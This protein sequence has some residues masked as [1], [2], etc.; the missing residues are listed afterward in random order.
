MPPE[1]ISPIKQKYSKIIWVIAIIGVVVIIGVIFRMAKLWTW[2][3][4]TYPTNLTNQITVNKAEPSELSILQK[5]YRANDPNGVNKNMDI[6]LDYYDYNLYESLTYYLVWSKITEGS[7]Y[8]KY[9]KEGDNFSNYKEMISVKEV[10]VDNASKY[11]E[12]Y[13]ESVKQNTEN[14]VIVRTTNKGLFLTY[15]DYFN[16]T[17]ILDYTMQ[18]IF[19]THTG[20]VK[21]FI[22]NKR[23]SYSGLPAEWKIIISDINKIDS[24]LQSSLAHLPYEVNI[25]SGTCK[26]SV[27]L[28]HFGLSSYVVDKNL[29]KNYYL[30]EG[31]IFESPEGNNFEIGS[32]KIPQADVATFKV[33]ST[34]YAKDKNRVYHDS[35][36]MVGKYDAVTGT[37]GKVDVETFT[38][39]P[40]GTG[41]DINTLYHDGIPVY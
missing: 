26:D 4:L 18:D 10:K 30:Y 3:N 24:N 20:V 41:K 36:E 11:I 7:Y 38:V 5:K 34:H 35:A 16:T 17:N 21:I 14:E 23:Y 6:S 22:Y 28:P 29:S 8:L 32:K 39:L 25:N 15:Y 33:L 13:I 37:Y 1:N 40:D 12:S 27:T 9:L 2:Y 19:D 31:C